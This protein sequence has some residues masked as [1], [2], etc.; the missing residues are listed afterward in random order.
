MGSNVSRRTLIAGAGG[1]GIAGLTGGLV[2]P[3]PASAAVKVG[4]IPTTCKRKTTSKGIKYEVV[5][6]DPTK[7]TKLL[8]PKLDMKTLT[9]MKT[10]PKEAATKYYSQYGLINCDSWANIDGKTDY[11]NPAKVARP[12]SLQVYNRKVIQNFGVTF[13][14]KGAESNRLVF[15]MKDGY[16]FGH[17]NNTGLTLAQEQAL[18]DQ[19]KATWSAGYGPNLV[20]YGKKQTI[21]GTAVSAH[22]CLGQKPDLTVVVVT[23]YGRTNQF[24]ATMQ[25]CCDIMFAEGCE[26]AVALDGGGSVQMFSNGAYIHASSDTKATGGVLEG[27][28]A[29]GGGYLGILGGIPKPV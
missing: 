22:T 25:D 19:S 14:E 2:L 1:L 21:A 4:S 8:N 10:T 13:S 15:V 6:C 24:G 18:I 16:K 5:N 3:A 9:G 12:V 29:L 28:R 23:I 7:I 27:E 26:N 20:V 11:N 17:V